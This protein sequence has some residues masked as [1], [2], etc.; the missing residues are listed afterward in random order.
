MLKVMSKNGFAE[1][2]GQK[3][4]NLRK[5]RG[6]SQEAL[7]DKAHLHR[8][9]VSLIERGL[10][11]VRLETIERLAKALEVQPAE[12]MPIRRVLLRADKR[13][14]RDGIHVIRR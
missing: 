4:S 8:T 13:E 5:A 3:V 6:L 7:A 1:R 9:A 2:F 10:R 11:N 14:P 12:M